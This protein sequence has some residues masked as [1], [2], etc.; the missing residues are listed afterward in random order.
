MG[1]FYLSERGNKP[2]LRCKIGVGFPEYFPEKLAPNGHTRVGGTF[3]YDWSRLA[4]KIRGETGKLKDVPQNALAGCPLK[5][6][7]IINPAIKVLE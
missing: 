2:R 4:I 1:M 3:S 5:L 6:N 7:H